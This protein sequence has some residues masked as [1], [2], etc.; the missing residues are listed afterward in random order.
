MYGKLKLSRVHVAIIAVEKQEVLH[1]LICVLA[2]II[3]H[4]K[5]MCC[6]ILTSVSCLTVPYF[7]T[8][9]YKQPDCWT[10]YEN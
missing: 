3:Q 8:L 1:N 7:S 9:Y 4:T 5:Q 10:I 2:S 6:F